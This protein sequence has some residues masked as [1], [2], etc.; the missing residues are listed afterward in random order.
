V[1][2]SKGSKIAALGLGLALVAAACSS[3]TKSSPGTTAGGT[4]T[5]AAAAST[6][7]TQGGTTTVA[8]AQGG[9]ITYAAEQEYTSYNN[10]AADQGLVANTLVLNLLQPGPYVQQ[11]DLTFKLFTDIATSVDVTSQSPQTVVYKLNPAAVWSDGV[12]ID[13][14]DFYLSWI[15]QNGKA[16]KKNPDYKKPGQK[17]KDGNEITATLPVFNPAGTTG[18]ENIK[19]VTCSDNNKTVTTV[20]DTPYVDYQGLFGSL[21]PA[22]I[23]ESNTGVADITK[24]TDAELVKV[25]DFWNTKFVGFDPKIDV[26][27]SWYVIDSFKPGETLVL[28][29]NP[30]YWGKPGNADEIVFRQVPDATQQPSALE[31]GDVQ[32]ISPQPNPDLL[33]QLQALSGVTTK[34]YAGVTFEHYDFNQANPFLKD[35]KVRQAFAKCIDR[36]QIVDT[37]VKPL[38]PDAVVLNNRMYIPQQ[39]DY[40]D[41]SGG[42]YAKAD[43]AASKALL[44]SAGFTFGADGIATKGGKKL[45]LRLGRRDP[46]TRRQ[47]TNELTIAS[48]KKAGFDLK[49]DADAKFNSNRLPASDYDIALFAWQ[50]T[51]LL[52]SNTSLY[53]PGGGQ[54]WNNYNN[55]KIKDL[56]AQANKEFDAAKRADLMNQVDTILWDDM[57]TLPLFQFTDAIANSDKVSGVVYHGALGV[58]W[59][60]NDWAVKS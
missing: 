24:A 13:C 60:G 30:K 15:S 32:V 9:T 17:D 45:T 44:T 18:Y 27:G 14:K 19:S 3:D 52:S 40:K 25:G 43:I 39:P 12:A 53:V 49:D 56:M 57:A 2:T 21:L 16:T 26:S 11:P 6:S 29:K 8:A 38:N 54:N 10:S 58:T 5:T 51:G 31:N 22:H 37:L 4:T 41:T 33:K 23:I 48:C 46:N 34:T 7:T 55:P 47:S 20:Y 42:G 28:K 50:N 35:L 59:N 1:R 36:Q